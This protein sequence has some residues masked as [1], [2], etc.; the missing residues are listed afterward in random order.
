VKKVQIT[1]ISY[2]HHS[3]IIKPRKVIIYLLEIHTWISKN[4]YPA[5]HLPLNI[6]HNQFLLTE[7]VVRNPWWSANRILNCTLQR[8]IWFMVFSRRW[9]ETNTFKSRM[10]RT[11]TSSI[12]WW[13]RYHHNHAWLCENFDLQL[14]FEIMTLEVKIV[15]Y[16]MLLKSLPQREK[17]WC[18]NCGG[19][20]TFRQHFSGH[21]GVFSGEKSKD[22]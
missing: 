5:S 7:A 2:S 4:K 20:K 3:I 12:K 14:S 22:T 9:A 17:H 11:S 15:W 21:Q 8:H 19:S 1:K 13:G 10:S 18:G 16:E 6:S